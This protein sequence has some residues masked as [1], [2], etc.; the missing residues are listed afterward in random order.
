MSKLREKDAAL[1]Y[2][3]GDCR[4]ENGFFSHAEEFVRGMG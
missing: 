1:R 2:S 4:Y 3:V